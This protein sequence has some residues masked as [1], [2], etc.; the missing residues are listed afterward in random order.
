MEYIVIDTNVFYNNWF[1]KNAN[2]SFISNYIE[3]TG[4][5]ILL[6]RIVCEEVQNKYETEF[7][8][9]KTAFQKNIRQLDNF[10]PYEIDFSLES[11]TFDFSK[12]VTEK[13]NRVFYVE[14]N[15]INNGQIVNRAIK[16]I[17]P[18]KEHEKGYRDTLIWLSVLSFLKDRNIKDN[19]IFITENYTDYFDKESKKFKPDLLNDIKEY[20]IQCNIVP[21]LNLQSFIE[22]LDKEEYESPT[23]LESL[24]KIIDEQEPDI[25]TEIEL[26][27]NRLSVN[28]IQDL[29]SIRSKY[30]FIETLLDFNFE[31]IEGIENFQIKQHKKIGSKE[32]YVNCELELRI[33]SF[34]FGIPQIDY[35]KNKV[36]INSEFTNQYFAEGNFAYFEKYIRPQFTINFIIHLDSEVITGIEIIEAIYTMKE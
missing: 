27:I 32:Y 7:E 9:I 30:P 20:G 21:Y 10:Y 31:I 5:T 25:E 17:A 33:C 13:F 24:Q 36:K 26:Y 16:K 6:S 4:S 14:Y 34:L 19:V 1:L 22:T 2:F 11:Y 28:D 35:D 8:S 18:F 29:F 3:N 15:N 23:M 12:V